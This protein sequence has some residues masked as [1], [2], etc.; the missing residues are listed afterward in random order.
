[1]AAIAIASKPNKVNIGH[2]E[3]RRG[4]VEGGAFGRWVKNIQI[5]IGG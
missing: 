5:D 3:G 1:M 2:A 4:Y